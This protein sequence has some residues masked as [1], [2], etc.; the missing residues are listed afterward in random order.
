MRSAQMA[1]ETIFQWQELKKKNREARELVGMVGRLL[2]GRF[3]EKNRILLEQRVESLLQSN[4]LYVSV[5]DIDS[6]RHVLL[7]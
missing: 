3:P 1:F 5:T 6:R 4:I 2:A 7:T